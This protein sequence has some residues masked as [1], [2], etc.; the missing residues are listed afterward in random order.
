M[1]FKTYLKSLQ[2]VH[3]AMMAGIVFFVSIALFLQLSAG[4]V[5][6]FADE[7]SLFLLIILVLTSGSIATSFIIERSRKNEIGAEPNLATKLVSYRSLQILTLALHEAP[8]F[9]SV[10]MYLLTG[11]LFFLGF[12]ISLLLLMLMRFPTES[13]IAQNLSLDRQQQKQLSEIEID[14]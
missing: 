10:V 6:A 1:K 5:Q 3:L 11:N 2:V 8:A 7:E 9:V 4:F 12:T 14:T 13:K